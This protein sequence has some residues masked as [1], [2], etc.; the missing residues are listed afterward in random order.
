MREAI[1]IEIS[2]IRI[3]GCHILPL[4]E[5]IIVGYII[6]YYSVTS[7]NVG[8]SDV[9]TYCVS[10]IINFHFKFNDRSLK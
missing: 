3:W 8:C 9:L 4:V 10:F 6:I 1:G 2:Y 7:Y 5:L